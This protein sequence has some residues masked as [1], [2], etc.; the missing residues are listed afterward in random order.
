MKALCCLYR[1]MLEGFIRSRL[2]V[3]LHT[4]LVTI[5]GHICCYGVYCV[6]LKPPLGHCISFS[7]WSWAHF[8]LLVFTQLV[9]LDI[10]PRGL[11]RVGCYYLSSTFISSLFGFLGKTIRVMPM[12]VLGVIIGQ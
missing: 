3:R 10:I 8:I 12:C 5:P 7:T 1:F 9:M 6:I 2:V 11:L 4:V